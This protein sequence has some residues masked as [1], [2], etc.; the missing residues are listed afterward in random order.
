MMAQPF[1]ESTNRAVSPLFKL[2]GGYDGPFPVGRYRRSNY[3]GSHAG[4][5]LTIG[6]LIPAVTGVAVFDLLCRIASCGWAI[7]LVIPAAFLV[8]HVLAFGMRL[9]RPQVSFW[10]WSAM[11][12]AWAYWVLSH[13]GDTHVKYVAWTWMVWMA[14]QAVGLLGLGW[15]DLAKMKGNVGLL[16]RV[17]IV[18]LIHI[19]YVIALLRCEG[20]SL[21][22]INVTVAGMWALWL[23]GTF[24]TGSSLFGPM[25]TRIAEE[26]VLLT[27]DDGPHPDCTPAILDALDRYDTK[28]VFFVIGERVK[29]YPELAREIVNRGHEIANHTM[30]HP[31][32]MMWGLGPIRTRREIK[33]A[34]ATI[35]E[36]TGILPRWFR[37][38][39]GHRNFFTHPV[40][41]QS[42]MQVIAWTHRAFDTVEHN[43]PKLVKRLTD[44][45]KPGDILLL[46][47][48]TP[49]AVELME[50][51][52]SELDQLKLLKERSDDC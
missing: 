19:G 50:A 14:L 27:I 25:V 24:R 37:A 42:G 28:A 13:G 17:L 39:V 31:Q 38:P 20:A 26:R 32:A 1:V 10:V 23:L 8:L 45:V 2:V 11:L 48:A 34:Q 12:T 5:C 52:L 29:K 4:E 9:R 7:A 40:T 41:E 35:K 16:F 15:R 21:V 49:V 22:L 46:H 33:D 3:P 44:G 6:L 18:L 30:T 47:E 43:V 51:V 36:V